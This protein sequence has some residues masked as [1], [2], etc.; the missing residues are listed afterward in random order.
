MTTCDACRGS[1]VLD[2]DNCP[3]CHGAGGYSHDPAEALSEGVPYAP[4]PPPE[5]TD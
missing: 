4:A 3:I 2:D 1:G 5:P